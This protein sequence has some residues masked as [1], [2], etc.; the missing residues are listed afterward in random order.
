VYRADGALQTKTCP[1]GVTAYDYD[2]FEN[3]RGV[4]LPNGTAITYIIDGQN[5]RIGKK[6]NGTLVES[7]VYEDQLKRLGWYD[8]TGAL[9]AQFVFVRRR[10]VPDL[11]IKGGQTFRL[12]YNQVGSVR[13]VV[14]LNGTA[15][16]LLDLR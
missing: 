5:R 2:A 14:D 8:G 10:Y 16:Q 6:I 15:W 11:M 12:I 13:Q 3:L 4:T 1:N 7:F 9:K